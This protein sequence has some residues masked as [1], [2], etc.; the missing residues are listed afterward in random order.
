MGQQGHKAHMKNQQT[1]GWGWKDNP[2][3]RSKLDVLNR[4]SRFAALRI[5]TGSHRL[6]IDRFESQGQK[7]VQIAA[8]AYYLSLLR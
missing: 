1:C 3:L 6:L 7:A 8:K 2:D 4:S 5:T